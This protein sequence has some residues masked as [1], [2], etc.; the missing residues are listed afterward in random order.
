MTTR[1]YSSPL[2]LVELALGVGPVFDAVRGQL[3]AAVANSFVL[4]SESPQK[5]LHELHDEARRVRVLILGVFTSILLDC[6]PL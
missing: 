2:E 4:R 3:N 5:E 1:R 6:G